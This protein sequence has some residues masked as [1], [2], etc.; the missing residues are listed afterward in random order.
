MLVIL[1]KQVVFFLLVWPW[2]VVQTLQGTLAMSLCVRNV[3]IEHEHPVGAKC[4]R[5][6]PVVKDEKKDMVKDIKRCQRTNLVMR[7]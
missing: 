6:K 1:L 2:L 3:G 7:L 4:D 5:N